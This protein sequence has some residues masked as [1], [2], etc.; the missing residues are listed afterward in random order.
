MGNG[1]NS[2]LDS[3]DT[4]SPM[5]DTVG[6]LGTADGVSSSWPACPNQ[7]RRRCQNKQLFLFLVDLIRLVQLVADVGLLGF[8]RTAKAVRGYVLQVELEPDPLPLEGGN[9]VCIAI[10]GLVQT[11]PVARASNA[12]ETL[13][14]RPQGRNGLRGLILSQRTKKG[15]PIKM[16]TKDFFF[17]VPPAQ[18]VVSGTRVL[19]SGFAIHG[20]NSAHKKGEQAI[21]N[22]FT[23]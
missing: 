3:D 5:V 17:P 14:W 1:T 9:S 7:G 11:N 2:P 22:E 20:T 10:P 23:H 15:F 4:Y 18:D 21:L 19:Y 6:E 12:P 8:F 13:L 16:I